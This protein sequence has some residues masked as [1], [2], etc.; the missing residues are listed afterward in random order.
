MNIRLLLPIALA[1]AIV[2]CGGEE[3]A[4]PA[5]P[6]DSPPERTAPPPRT[7][8]PATPRG[9]AATDHWFHG[10]VT[11]MNT[12]CYFDATCSVTVEVTESLGGAP[13]DAGS[14]VVVITSYGY[15]IQRCDGQWAEMPPGRE[16][17]VLAHA[18]EGQ[19]LA[20]CAGDHYFVKDVEAAE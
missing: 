13:M 2:A 18:A 11:E 6:T 9:M 4:S 3:E 19:T 7:P 16:V 17:E 14:E 15:S 10:V 12:G 5:E 8:A 20:V 1:T